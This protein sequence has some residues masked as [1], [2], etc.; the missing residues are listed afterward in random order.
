V[1]TAMA[2]TPG[3]RP[4]RPRR[5]LAR[6]AWALAGLTV[7]TMVPAFWLAELVF[8]TGWEPRPA[9]ATLGAVVLA[10]V[11]A[12]AVG[13]LVASRRPRHPVGGCCSASA[14]R[15]WSPC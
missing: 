10:T 13:A 1:P 2:M 7:L 15:W 14:W 5:W 8:S 4:A 12:A 6:L 11:S 3:G 9:T